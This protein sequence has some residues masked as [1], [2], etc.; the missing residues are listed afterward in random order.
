MAPQ[1]SDRKLTA[2]LNSV[3]TLPGTV[4]TSSITMTLPHSA[5]NLRMALVL[6]L[7]QVFSSCTSV[8]I[9]IG[10][11]QEAVSSSSSCKRS[12]VSFG[13]ARLE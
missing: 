11:D 9:M 3:S 4:C 6:P 8:V 1:I 2:K 12:G 7:K 10:A 13:S 5:R